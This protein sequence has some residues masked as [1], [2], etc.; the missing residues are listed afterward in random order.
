MK[1]I[2]AAKSK[3]HKHIS[4]MRRKYHILGRVI[5]VT[6]CAALILST[7]ELV[8]PALA[9]TERLTSGKEIYERVSDTNTMDSYVQASLGGWLVDGVTS[10]TVRNNDGSRYAGEVWGG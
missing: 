2:N 3:F 7:V 6:L 9:N 5:A 10:P 8:K 4:A 1:K